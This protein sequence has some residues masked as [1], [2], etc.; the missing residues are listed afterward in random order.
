MFGK[1]LYFYADNPYKILYHSIENL[2]LHLTQVIKE[3]AQV[4]W[5]I[6]TG[7]TS[8]VLGIWRITLFLYR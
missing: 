8:E 2:I 7:F 6:R 1:K 4:I 3:P 5:R